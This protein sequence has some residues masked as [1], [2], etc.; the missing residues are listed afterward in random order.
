M[1]NTPAETGDAS[2]SLNVLGPQDT[3]A[4]QLSTPAASAMDAESTTSLLRH[5]DNKKARSKLTAPSAKTLRSQEPQPHDNQEAVANPPD[6]GGGRLARFNLEDNVFDRQQRI[7]SRIERTQDKISAHRPRWSKGSEG[8]MVRAQKMLVRVEQ[9]AREL[10]P[11]YSENDSL[12][13]ES[14]EIA[15]WREYVVVC[16]KASDEHAPFTLKMYK[17]RVIQ[18][19]EKSSS[20]AYYEIPLNHKR[21]RV[22]LYSSLDKTVVI[23]HPDKR[24][25]RIYI[26]RPRSSAH[27]VEWY[28][29]IRQALGWHRPTSLLINVPDLGI[30]LVFKDPFDQDH[31]GTT[32][33]QDNE[34]VKRSKEKIAAAAI[35]RE[36]M[37][38]IK[39]RNEWS[40]VLEGWSKTAKMGLA[41]K[42][43]DR[44]EWIHGANEGQMYGTIA[45][46]SSH[47]LELRPKH[48]YPATVK[49]FSNTTEEPAPLEGF[50]VRLTSQRGAQQRFGKK[51]YK[52][53]YFYTQ[54]RFLCFCKQGKA[55]PPYP[56]IEEIEGDAM[57]SHD[58]SSQASS[59]DKIDPFSI[60]DE[61]IAW[62]DNGNEEFIRRRD[63][64]AFAHFM[65]TIHN[66]TNS[67]GYLDLCQ[68]QSIQPLNSGQ[69]SQ[70]NRQNNQNDD[71]IFEITLDNGFKVQ[72]EA[73]NNGNR[74][75]W[76]KR[77]DEL[78]QYWMARTKAD[79]DELRGTRYH[80]LKLLDIDERTESILGQFASKWEVKR[81]EASPHLYNM[82]HI[83]G[84]RPIKVTLDCST[85][86][87]IIM[88]N[89]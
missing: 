57:P 63:E 58:A 50:L 27:A 68:V 38:M 28:T 66:L 32:G 35:I 84:C 85:I 56:S 36:C 30:S 59:S 18:D 61:S 14:R 13:M 26:V 34:P 8:E 80:N 52:R 33:S 87:Q 43:F 54:D 62:L 81:A 70:S 5:R 24:G 9:T 7:R 89:V 88:T 29:F 67:D 23:W 15:K 3:R 11:D 53:Q 78:S 51:F 55:I 46:Q 47:D 60:R 22:N 48:H 41:W 74:D 25:T 16:R 1:P 31:L 65:R 75:E 72:F 12:R 79:A 2:S 4:S 73:Q 42:R 69:T 19:V 76:V 71:C 6:K 20:S 44:L 21:T 83:T 49:S 86:F 17:S 45:M 82:C 40:E 77:L 10:P 39:E 37:S 64:T